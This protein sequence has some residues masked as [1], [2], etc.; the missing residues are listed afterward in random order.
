MTKKVPFAVRKK[1]G[2]ILEIKRMLHFSEVSFTLL[3]LSNG[4]NL[5]TSGFT[6][7]ERQTSS[8]HT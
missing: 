3:Y 6:Q 8:F 2:K 5:Q 4:A 1:K 7:N